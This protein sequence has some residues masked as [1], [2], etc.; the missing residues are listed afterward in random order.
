MLGPDC[1]LNG[2]GGSQKQVCEVCSEISRE[3]CG[4]EPMFPLIFFR[5]ARKFLKCALLKIFKFVLKK[6]KFHLRHYISCAHAQAH[7]LEET[8]IG[9]WS[10]IT[11]NACLI[12]FIKHN[13]A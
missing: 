8:L 3:T 4:L 6:Y 2:P 10:Y 7:T 12:I 11:S 13:D 1:S 9:T 5:H